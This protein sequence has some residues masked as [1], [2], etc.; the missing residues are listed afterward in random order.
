[1]QKKKER[2]GSIIIVWGGG[3]GDPLIEEH[4]PSQYSVD[5]SKCLY[6]GPGHP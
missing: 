5:L 4:V 3:G 2:G 6:P 1:M